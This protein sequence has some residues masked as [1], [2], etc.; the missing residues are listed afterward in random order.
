MSY[1]VGEVVVGWY[2]L[3][4]SKERLLKDRE[5]TTGAAFI[6][7][8]FDWLAGPTERP[9]LPMVEIDGVIQE[10]ALDAFHRMARWPIDRD[11]WMKRRGSHA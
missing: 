5:W 8:P 1:P 3:P 6:P 2:M 4:V 9:R 7:C 11:D 10:D